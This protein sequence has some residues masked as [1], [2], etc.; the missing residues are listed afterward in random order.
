MKHHSSSSSDDDDVIAVA[1]TYLYRQM[2][3]RETIERIHPHLRDM[4]KMLEFIMVI[5]IGSTTKHGC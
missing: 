2:Q 4:T 3:M 1:T 5:K